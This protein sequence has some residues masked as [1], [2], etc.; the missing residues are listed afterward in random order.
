ME[1][2]TSRFSGFLGEA[3]L[4]DARQT[5]QRFSIPIS[6]PYSISDVSP[7]PTPESSPVSSPVT[8]VPTISVKWL[9]HQA[10]I[11]LND[12][13]VKDFTDRSQHLFKVFD[14]SASRINPVSNSSLEETVRLSIW[15]FLLGNMKVEQLIREGSSFPCAKE[16]NNVLLQQ[17]LVEIAKALWII[18]SA[19][20]VQE[21]C[22][23]EEEKL[24]LPLLSARLTVLGRIRQ[25]VWAI[26]RHGLLPQLESDACL[27]PSNDSAIWIDYPSVGLDIN[28]LLAGS[29]DSPRRP[30]DCCTLSDAFLLGDTEDT[31]HYSSIAVDVYLFNEGSNSQQI[32]YPCV[33]SILRGVDEH[34]ISIVVSSQNGLLEFSITPEGTRKPTWEDVTWLFFI[35]SLEVK[36]PTGFRLQ[37]RFSPWDFRTLKRMYDH[38]CMTLENFQPA[39]GEE[40]LRF[41]TIVKS[42][43]YHTTRQSRPQH[44]PHGST[45]GCTLRLFEKSVVRSAGTGPKTFHT[46][47]RLALMTPPTCK[48]LSIVVHDMEPE[49][50]I[51]F[52]FLRGEDGNPA[53]SLKIDD[54]DPKVALVLAFSEPEQR[55]KLLAH[56]TGSFIKDDETILAQAPLSN[57]TWSTD[58]HPSSPTTTP[59]PLQWHTVLVISKQPS[60]PDRLH[61]SN[62]QSPTPESLR[63]V[64]DSTNARITDRLNIGIGELLIRR[65]VIASGHELRIWRQPQ[66]D[67][68]VSFSDLP[69]PSELPEQL[70][71]RLKRIQELPSIRTYRFP[72]L[73]DLHNFQAA[74]T[75]FTVLF[76]GTPSSFTISRRRMMVPITKEW[77]SPHTRIQILQRGRQ[78]QLA[79]FFEGFSKGECMN[80][81]LKGTDV[82][83][84][85]TKG[86]VTIVKMV[87]AKFALPSGGK[88]DFRD[89]R[90]FVCLDV[91]E[92]PGEH[93]DICVGFA[94]GNDYERFAQALPAPV[95]GK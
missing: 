38:C 33:L 90:G 86:G 14:L 37:L 40:V 71:K 24:Q 3:G 66:E 88:R 32:K 31:F 82:F 18:Q 65:N 5:E 94:S 92:Y 56:I 20:P 50:P 74:V 47:Y 2:P 23:S 76:D 48:K 75:G 57:F 87:D 60:D 28:V 64:L 43:D 63:I 85:S 72:N 21:A 84:K 27:L 44:F 26:G 7:C 55:N 83:E 95:R 16:D 81:A 9:S 67:L 10:S 45:P 89:E 11:I 13:S 68:T 80:F 69:V 52:E 25:A 91:L 70:T 62:T 15:W 34:N 8:S 54:D 30:H 1:S 22:S 36:L 58:L 29:N 51:Q 49:Q 17:A 46:G 41:E 53:L 79:A 73:S 39:Q 78:I 6:P 93:N 59:D 77:S 12:E 35:N 4:S 19:R 61:S 42:T